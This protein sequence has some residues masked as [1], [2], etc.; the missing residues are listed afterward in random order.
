[1]VDGFK[2]IET[3][4]ETAGWREPLLLYDL[5]ADPWETR[6]LMGQEPVIEGYALTLLRERQARWGNRS[7]PEVSDQRELLRQLES[8][9]YLR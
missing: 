9:Q 2:L 4:T 3:R 6:D 1:M 5:Q 7:A 8:L